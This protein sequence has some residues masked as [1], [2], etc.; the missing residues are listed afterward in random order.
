MKLRSL[1]DAGP[2][3]R[4]LGCS[5]TPIFSAD[6]DIEELETEVVDAF[7][8]GEHT[9]ILIV[10]EEDDDCGRT[11]AYEAMV[12]GAVI[13]GKWDVWEHASANIVMLKRKE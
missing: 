2:N 6:K 4:W 9:H 12:A 1:A 3:P 8:S 11:E 10:C 5:L 7:A 13:H